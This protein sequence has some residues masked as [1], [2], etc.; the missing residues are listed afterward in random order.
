[1]NI[2]NW[3]KWCKFVSLS[4]FKNTYGLPVLTTYTK[5]L[6]Q[7]FSVW[8]VDLETICAKYGLETCFSPNYDFC[9]CLFDM[10]HGS[11]EN[12]FWDLNNMKWR[13]WCKFVP[14]FIFNNTC[15]LLVFTM[16]TKCAN[17]VFY[18]WLVDLQ[19][20]CAK[21]GRERWFYPNDDIRK[22]LI[23]MKHSWTKGAISDV[24]NKK[25]CNWW[26]FVSPFLFDDTYGLP[27]LAKDN[28]CPNQYFMFGW[29]IY[30]LLVL[31]TGWKRDT[32][33]NDIRIC[34]PDKKRS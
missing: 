32:S 34:F 8:L 16:N 30:I 4:L 14:P 19:T 26:K 12:A 24:N 10:K 11:N 13:K 33:N 17:Q 21:Y 22:C 9:K 20:I 7:V 3:R 6:N 2:K 18:V 27:V 31:N 15:G 23:D 1:V 28:K 5:R 29:S 25:W